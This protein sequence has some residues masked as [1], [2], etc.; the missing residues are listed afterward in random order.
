MFSHIF[1]QISTFVS[2]ESTLVIFLTI[3]I[4]IELV[5][6]NIKKRMK[7]SI[8]SQ[9][10]KSTDPKHAEFYLD[11]YRRG[12]VIDIIRVSSLLVLVSFFVVTRTGAGVNFFV[13]A[14]GALLIIFKDFIL[15]IIAFF[16]VI[17]RYKIGDT[18]GVSD[19]QWQIIYIRMFSIGILGKDNDGDST[20][21]MYVVP[22][23]RLIT[24]QIKKEDLHT[25]SIRKEL[26]R[27]PFKNQ[28]F[29]LTFEEFIHE[30]ESYIGNFLPIMTR[31]NCGNYQTYIGHKYKMDLDYLEDKCVV[32]TIGIVGKWSQNVENKKKIITFVESKRER[33]SK[34]I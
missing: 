20:G 4:V 34:N 3:A 17:R 32:V 25:N 21:R 1:S 16:V 22:S 26:I 18:I 33:F 31:K 6:R 28:D 8:F 13:I 10:D 27:I 29:I 9:Y 24:E 15:S 19:I 11:Y 2:K 14:A 12:Q 7:Q 23:H 5:S 30:L